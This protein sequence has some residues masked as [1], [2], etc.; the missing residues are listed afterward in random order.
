[1]GKE[2]MKGSQS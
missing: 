1:M 2:M